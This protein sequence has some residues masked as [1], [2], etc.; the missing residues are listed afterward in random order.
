MNVAD[1][2]TIAGILK[3]KGYYSTESLKEADL[4]FAITCAVR[5]NAEQ[6]IYGKLG[7]LSKLKEN[8]PHL[9]LGIGGCMTQQDEIAKHIYQRFP[10]I[11]IVFGTDNLHSLSNDL[12]AI[13]EESRRILDVHEITGD[14]YEDLPKMHSENH[15]AFV[16]INFGCNNFCTYC[17]VPHVRGRERSRSIESIYDEVYQLGNQGYREVTLLGQN[18]NSYGN[19]LDDK[20][21]FVQ[22]LKSLL[23]IEN[24]KRIRFMTSH[25]KDMSKDL[26]HLV[27]DENKLCNHIHLPIQ[28]GS[29]KVLKKM[30]RRYDQD[31]YLDLARYIRNEIPQATITTDIIVG[32]P[33][34]TEEDFLETMKVVDEIEFDSAYTFAYSKRPGTPAAKFEDQVPEEDKKNRLYRLIDQ[35]NMYMEKSNKSRL[36]K[37]I[38]IMVDGKSRKDDEVWSGRSDDN[39]L[40]HFR[41]DYNVGDIIELEVY[42]Y[43][44]HVLWAK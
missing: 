32:F 4:I 22:L 37:K 25:P 2:E 39:K 41:G 33:G 24:I 34:E 40:V 7:E 36:G 31:K 16:N 38:S 26:I 9:I 5:D 6:K 19:D 27:R 29:S 8:K 13:I 42:D 28:S 23:E 14:I 10:S 43:T 3:T 17:I 12:D 44:P 1:S 11:N 18:V 15:R 21:N 35:V 20:I 30:N